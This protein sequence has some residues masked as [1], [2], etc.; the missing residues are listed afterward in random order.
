[1][2]ACFIRS[3]YLEQNSEHFSAMNTVFVLENS[4][5]HLDLGFYL[6]VQTCKLR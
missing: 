5:Y 1:M 6:E 4:D 3:G 2:N